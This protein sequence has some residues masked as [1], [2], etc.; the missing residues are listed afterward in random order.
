VF[1]NNRIT[2]S[3]STSASDFSPSH[4]E[5][6]LLSTYI[7]NTNDSSADFLLPTPSEDDP[8]AIKIKIYMFST[9]KFMQIYIYKKSSVADVIR[10]IMTL[11]S[12][13]KLLSGDMPLKFPISPE[14][15]ELRLIDDDEDYFV[16]FYDVPPLDKKDE[17]GEF[18]SLAFLENKNFKAFNKNTDIEEEDE[19][20]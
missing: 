10:H 1:K 2:T 15:Y 5:A 19:E 14:A 8:A 9:P 13:D 16:P 17:I 11:Y 3:K 18:E 20:T 7:D 12:K 6:S 4:Q